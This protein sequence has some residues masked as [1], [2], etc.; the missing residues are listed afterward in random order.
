MKNLFKDLSNGLVKQGWKIS[1]GN[2]TNYLIFTK[3]KKTIKVF[4]MPA[5]KPDYFIVRYS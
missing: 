2:D 5:F 3:G 4:G 1:G